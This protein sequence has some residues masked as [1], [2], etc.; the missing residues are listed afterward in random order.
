MEKRKLQGFTLF[1]MALVL[2]AV[3]LLV[4]GIFVGRDIINSAK[5]RAVLRESD[6]YRQAVQAFQMKYNAMPGDMRKPNKYWPSAG[7]TDDYGN[8]NSKILWS[9]EGPYAWKQ[10]QLAGLINVPDTMSIACVQDCVAT[11]GTNIPRSGTVDN[12]GWT[13]GINK[14]TLRNTLMFGALST[15]SPA[16]YIATDPI[17]SPREVYEMDVKVDDGLPSSG[18]FRSKNVSSWAAGNCISGSAYILTIT[19]VRCN[20]DYA[21]GL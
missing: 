6:N 7:F 15:S 19:T 20:F 21:I 2:I 8:G 12:A 1:E 17:L 5:L 10:L 16:S 4:A 18:V 13:I 9:D 14:D 11:P 3:S